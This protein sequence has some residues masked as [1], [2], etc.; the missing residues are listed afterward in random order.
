MITNIRYNIDRLKDI[1]YQNHKF[2]FPDLYGKGVIIYKILAFSP[3][4]GTGLQ[5]INTYIE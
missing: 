1:L 5:K 4:N 2:N 3:K